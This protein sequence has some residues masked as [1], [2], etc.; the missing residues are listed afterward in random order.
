MTDGEAWEPAEIPPSRDR[1]LDLLEQSL[2]ELDR[3]EEQVAAI[4]VQWA[5]DILTEA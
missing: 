4:H 2:V 3:L 5:I 1:A